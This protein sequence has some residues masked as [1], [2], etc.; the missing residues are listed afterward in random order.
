[1]I[2]NDILKVIYEPQ[3]IFKQIIENPKYLG[4]LII[5]LLFI[6]LQVG[7]EY[8]QF[9]KTYTEQ[10]SPTIDQLPTF[11]NASAWASSPGV[12]LSNNYVDYFNYSI[13]V[14]GFGTT[15]TNPLGYY[16]V[17]GN[18]SLQID[19]ANT[20][21]VSA[22]L[23]NAFNVDCSAAGFQNLSMTIK[24]VEPQA[25][26]QNVTLTLYSLS[27]SNFYQ[28]DLTPSLSNT[29][30]I[31]LWNNLTIPVG[32]V[33]PGWTSSG[34]P[35]WSNVTALKLDFTYAANSNVTLRIGGL[36]FRGQYQT[37][38]QYNSTG[39]LLQFL[40]VFSLQF[41]FGWFLITGLIYLI[42]KGL[43]SSVTWK[44]LF[45]ALGFALFVMVIRALVNLA[46]TLIL[47]AVY[48]PFDLSLG[49]RFDPYGVVFYPLEAVGTLSA[50]SQAVFNSIESLTAAFRLITSAM[51]VVSYVW[52]GA[53][54]TMI[55]GAL[56]P[57]FS[58]VKRIVISAVSIAVTILLLL[59][60][61]GIA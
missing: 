47:P 61:V 34:A 50:Q 12:T 41:I 51:F 4:A 30:A 59:L 3:K 9:S 43:K 39:I 53:L 54:G 2:I 58:M 5:L 24:M 31:G 45:I 13:Y 10:T 49:V 35:T 18:S 55:V 44:P 17:F 25:A 15:P 20:N 19:A 36:F 11:T 42:F 57:E 37:P 28:Y 56:K 14:A 32:T 8:S 22:A 33:A 46:G 6:G 1:M 60:L 21:N 48:Y 27:D 23:G 26:P 16:S 38:I 7:Y 29:S 52:L 40:Q